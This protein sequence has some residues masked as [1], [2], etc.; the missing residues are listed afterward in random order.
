MAPIRGVAREKR[1][2]I[3]RDRQS[4]SNCT[5]DNFIKMLNRMTRGSYCGA[6]HHDTCGL[7]P[8]LSGREVFPEAA[9]DGSLKEGKEHFGQKEEHMQRAWG[10]EGWASVAPRVFGVTR[11]PSAMCDPLG[12]FLK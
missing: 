5:L 10:R 3:K 9:H 1:Y 6:G 7:C 8:L 12:S 2:L 4:S 11:L